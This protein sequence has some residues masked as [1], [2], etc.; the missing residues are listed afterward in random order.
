MVITPKVKEQNQ[1]DELQRTVEKYETAF[2]LLAPKLKE[3]KKERDDLKT[4]LGDVQKNARDLLENATLWKK[5]RDNLWHYS[6]SLEKDMNELASSGAQYS[7]SLEKER[8]ELRLKLKKAKR[9]LT[10]YK[11][12]IK[13]NK[14]TATEIVVDPIDL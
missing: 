4:Q 10:I 6:A 3:M 13:K 1:K 14:Q 11:K 12:K 2:G 8:N 9:R 7:E 5:D